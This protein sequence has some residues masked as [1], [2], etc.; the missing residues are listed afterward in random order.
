MHAC[1]T[2][3]SRLQTSFMLSS[4][5]RSLQFQRWLGHEEE[6]EFVP[7]SNHPVLSGHMLLRRQRDEK[8]EGS[9]WDELLCRGD[10]SDL[11]SCIS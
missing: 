9:G 7:V 2:R 8:A 1:T 5:N 6:A 10:L 3:C 11:H 4:D